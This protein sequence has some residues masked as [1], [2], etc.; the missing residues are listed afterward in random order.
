MRL[1]LN[2]ISGSEKDTI[3]IG[4]QLGTL[5]RG[6]D[7][8]LLK[9]PLGSGKTRLAKGIVSRVTGLTE[10]DVVSPTFTLINSYEGPLTVQH[11]DLYR[12]TPERVE[13][14][15]LEDELDEDDLVIIEWA[16]R[17]NREL[18]GS[19]SIEIDFGDHPDQRRITFEWSQGSGWGARLG[20]RF[21]TVPS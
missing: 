16:E 18:P 17:M 8:I 14:I 15:G 3:S 10:N 5:A 2:L 13:E 21:Q 1:S 11:A 12:L 6:G 19:L 20:N 9:G 7:F 4:R